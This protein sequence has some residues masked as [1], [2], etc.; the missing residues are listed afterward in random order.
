[1]GCGDALLGFFNMFS[2]FVSVKSKNIQHLCCKV[3]EDRPGHQGSTV[4][5]EPQDPGRP[6]PAG[7]RKTPSFQL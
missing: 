2:H 1:M 7:P 4:H 3:S 6:L 5:Y